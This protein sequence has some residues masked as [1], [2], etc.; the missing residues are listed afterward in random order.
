M[1]RFTP[2]QQ[3]AIDATNQELLVSAAAGSGKT[4]VL[5]ERIVQMIASRGYSID[6]MLIVTFTRAAAGEMRERLEMR[7]SDLAQSDD[8]LARQADLVPMA[9]ISTIHAFCQQAVRQNFQHC[10]IDPQ[11]GL[12]DERTRAAMY[13]DSKNQT[14]DQLYTMALTDPDIAAFTAKFPEKTLSDIMDALYRFLLSRPDPMDWLDRYADH[15]WRLNTLDDEPMARAFCQEAALM[16]DSMLGL[17]QQAADLTLDPAF[18]DKY[19]TVVAADRVTLND[20][21]SACQSGMRTLMQQTGQIRWMRMPV[22]KPTTSDE[23]ALSE[24]YKSLRTQYKAL[25]DELKKLLP[26]DPAAAL[27]DM[28]VMAPAMRGLQKAIHLFHQIFTDEK[29]DQGLI[30]FGDLEHMTLSILRQPGLQRELAGRFDAVFVDEYQDVSELQEAILNGLKRHDGT[31]SYFYVGDVKQ[32]IYRFRLAEPGLFLRKLNEFSPEEN[33]PCRRIVLN[34]NFRSR[35]GVLDAVNRVF[36]HVMDSRVTEIDYDADAMLYPGV[37]SQNDPLTEVHVLNSADLRSE[38]KVLAEAEL[39]A[40]DIL[41]HVDTPT[42]EGGPL[43]RYSD[44]AILL[45]AAKNVADKVEKVLQKHGIPV[46]CEGLGQAF[47]STEVTQL[48]QYLSLLDNLMNDVA[49]IAVLRSPLF[50]FTEQMLADV[51]L[52]KPEREASY[53]SAL[54]H[55]ADAAPSPLRDSCRDALDTLKKERFYI[56]SMPLSQ[57]LWDFLSRSGLYVFYGAQPGGKARQANLR[58]VCQ[59]ASDWEKNHTDGLHGFVESLLLSQQNGDEASPALVNPWENVVRIM[60]I[61]RSKGLEFPTV[62][63]MGLGGSLLRKSQTSSVSMHGDVGFALSYV[64]EKL[65]TRRATL[66]QSAISLREKNAERAER[67]RVL[68]VAMTRPKE[69]LVLVGSAPLAGVME[70]DPLPVGQ[71]GIHAVRSAK[72]MLDWVLQSVSQGDEIA[73][74]KQPSTLSTE[75][76]WKTNPV[77]QFPTLST[78]F[79][80]KSAH[81]KVLFHIEPAVARLS[82][83]RKPVALPLVPA[84]PPDGP[85][86]LHRPPFYRQGQPDPLLGQIDQPHFPL[87]IGVTALCRAMENGE[88]PDPEEETSDTKRYP[89]LGHRPRLLPEEPPLPAFLSPP[90]E[91]AA[92]QRGVQTHRLLGLMDLDA[93][94]ACKGD[95]RA[96][97]ACVCRELQSLTDCAAITPQEASYCDRSMVARFL[98]SDLGQRMLRSPEVHREWSFSLQI[99]RPFHT[100][101]QGVIDLCFVED[102]AWVLADYKTDKVTSPADLLPRYRQQLAFYRQALQSATPLKVK[103]SHLFSLRLGEGVREG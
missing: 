99:H 41:S 89:L 46:Y 9:Q 8:R 36:C 93:A 101:L 69:R 12:C 42:A 58:L 38:D 71:R 6:R 68:Y 39:I 22:F 85:T 86:G 27:S 32:S 77:E 48:I 56:R 87:K 90:K 72:S 13:E 88:T 82:A 95:P 80:Q 78:S 97:Y 64:N 65:R 3:A 26:A 52:L 66:L 33:A 92:L 11:F 2:A 25:T 45:P 47:Q 83:A 16:I 57:Y 43:T 60:T 59:R 4:A 63:V 28:A 15:P 62:Y 81:W 54:M 67:A 61:H 103:E 17:W 73:L 76:V 94:R 31:Q 37:P 21:Q 50:H 44:M 34:R 18:P 7:L 79:P 40:R 100:H 10:G 20:L 70:G 91:E 23:A 53:L 51:R 29:K 19:K 14:L 5:V 102:G 30:D 98:Q 35:T 96:L 1:M 74:L 55:A 24:A 75:E 49:L 84:L